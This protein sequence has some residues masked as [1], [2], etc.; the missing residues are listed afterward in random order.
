MTGPLSLQSTG[1]LWKRP[2]E[3]RNSHQ[4]DVARNYGSLQLRRPVWQPSVVLGASFA[5]NFP[6]ETHMKT[7][8]EEN[9]VLQKPSINFSHGTSPQPNILTLTGVEQAYVF[10]PFDSLSSAPSRSLIVFLSGFILLLFI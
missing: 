10:H 3:A 4:N 9:P 5:L 8:T 2:T 7:H 6:T 1:A